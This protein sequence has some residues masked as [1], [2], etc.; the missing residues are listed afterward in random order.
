M[1]YILGL[2]GDKGGVNR[3]LREFGSKTEFVGNAVWCMNEIE[4]SEVTTNC[5]QLKI[6]A[7]DG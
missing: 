1:G 3:Q 6:Q 7:Y 5:S 4:G 2:G